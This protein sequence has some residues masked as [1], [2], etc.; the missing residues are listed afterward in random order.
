[1]KILEENLK[2]FE[3]F[4][5][6]NLFHQTNFDLFHPTQHSWRPQV[7][8]MKIWRKKINFWN[9]QSFNQIFSNLNKIWKRWKFEKM[10][11]WKD[12][13]IFIFFPQQIFIF[14][15]QHIFIFFILP[16]IPDVRKWK[17]WKF[18]KDENLKKKNQFFEIFNLSIKSFE[19]QTK[20][21]NVKIWKRW[22]FEKMK[23]FNE[24]LNIFIFFNFH[25][26]NFHLFHPTQHSW[27]PQVKKMKIWKDENLKKKIQ[28]LKFSIFQSNLSKFKQNLKIWKRWKF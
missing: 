23:I 1:M 26:S 28:F 11:I 16:S 12:L 18:E 10:K 15:T 14:F 7:K 9:F 6:F 19:I 20:F 21:E 17:R 27:R 13:K 22:N 5:L 4:H 24:N 2:R 3:N 25:P 8:K